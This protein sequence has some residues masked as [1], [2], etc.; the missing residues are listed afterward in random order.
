MS[1]TIAMPMMMSPMATCV[2]IMRTGDNNMTGRH[3]TRGDDER[4]TDPRLDAREWRFLTVYFYF[5]NKFV[6][7]NVSWY[8]YLYL[9]CHINILRNK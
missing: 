3:I 7:T 4:R 2:V 1:M 5:Y 6:F 8:L 9:Y